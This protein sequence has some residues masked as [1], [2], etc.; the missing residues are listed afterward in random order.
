ME[1]RL[2]MFRVDIVNPNH[3]YPA[4]SFEDGMNESEK[5]RPK[6]SMAGKNPVPSAPPAGSSLTFIE[7]VK[8][9]RTSL[10]ALVWGVKDYRDRKKA[11]VPEHI[12]LLEAGFHKDCKTVIGVPTTV[13]KKNPP[14]DFI[15][16][17]FFF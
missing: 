15:G 1:R 5:E 13:V 6:K 9:Y 3:G 8:M 12:K 11:T 16:P 4:I 10:C 7:F 17:T 14:R 2:N